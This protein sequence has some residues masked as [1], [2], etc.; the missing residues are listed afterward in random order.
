MFES[1]HAFMASVSGRSC[2]YAGRRCRRRKG[3][4]EEGAA[5]IPGDVVEA[6]LDG[7]QPYGAHVGAAAQGV[8][9]RVGGAEPLAGPRIVRFRAKSA[10][11]YGRTNGRDWPKIGIGGHLTVP[12]LPHHRAYGSRTTAVRAVMLGQR[13]REGGDRA[14][15]S[16]GCARPVGPPGVLTCAR[17]PSANRRQPQH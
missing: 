1:L 9:G 5:R 2:E 8:S 15:R 7:R 11:K 17:I 16:S 3:A 4:L 6:I 14:T 13:Q 12:P 10:S